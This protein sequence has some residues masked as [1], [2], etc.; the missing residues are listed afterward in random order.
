MTEKKDHRWSLEH[1]KN[2][3]FTLKHSTTPVFRVSVQRG[4]NGF[5]YVQINIGHDDN[6]N[7]TAPN[8]L[9]EALPAHQL[10]LGFDIMVQEYE[11][12]LIA[13]AARNSLHADTMHAKYYMEPNE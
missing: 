1:D 6:Y 10:G 9:G 7:R 4:D 8:N 5:E 13:V 2:G 11:G 12:L 3:G